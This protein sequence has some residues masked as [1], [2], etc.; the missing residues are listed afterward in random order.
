MKIFNNI[1]EFIKNMKNEHK[2]VGGIILLVLLLVLCVIIWYNTNLKAVSKQDTTVQISIEMGSGSSLIADVLKNNDVIRNETA[3]K[4]YIKLNNITGLQAGNYMLNK[5]MDVKEIVDMLKTGKVVKEQ[6]EITFI[7]G[8]N[9]GWLANKIAE[10]TDNSVEDVYNLLKDK[11]YIKSLI[12]NYWFL[13]DVILNE[14][15]YYP[16]EGYLF[17]DTYFFEKGNCDVKLIFKTMLDKMASVLEKHKE[18]IKKSNLSI[19][20]ILTLASI[21]ELEC[22]P[23]SS[24]NNTTRRDTAAVFYNRL[25]SNMSLGSDVTTYYAFKIN[26]ADRDLTQTELNT[27]NAYNTRGPNMNG[28]L[29]IG[30]IAMVS[31]SA[32]DAA[33]NPTNKKY[34]Y[35][36]ADKKGN[37]H[38]A[39]T[40][41]EHVNIVNDLKNKGLWF[42]Y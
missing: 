31:N 35:F 16:L 17:P 2:I 9:M 12:S 19:H 8:K 14:N 7:E 24:K 29:P 18:Q 37:V 40:Y 1:I 3:F 4:L 26:M 39:T 38:F 11:E 30:P 36:V 33:L 42:E 25:N 21:V 22:P 20:E 34:L 10:T 32:I 5:N 6:V 13:E 15:I 41:S 23:D 27:S 28:K